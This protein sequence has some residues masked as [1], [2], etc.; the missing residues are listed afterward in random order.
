MN[1]PHETGK[2]CNQQRSDSLRKIFQGNALRCVSRRGWTAIELLVVVVCLSLLLA[3]LLPWMI[4]SRGLARSQ[5]CQERLRDNAQAT[6]LYAENHRDALPP[7][8]DELGPWP[9]HLLP[10]L[11]LPESFQQSIADG[12]ELE[13]RVL[14][15]FL[16]PEDPGSSNS[17]TPLSYVMN[18]GYGEFRVENARQ[19]NV[20]VHEVGIHRADSDWNDDGEVTAEENQRSLCTGVI[21]RLAADPA[22]RTPM[23]TGFIRAGDGLKYTVLCAESLSAQSWK[24]R[25]TIG[26]GFVIDRGHLQFADVPAET[27]TVPPLTGA[28]LGPFAINASLATNDNTCPAP[29]SLHGDFAHVMFCDGSGKQLS[30]NIDPLAWARLMSSHGAL[31][32]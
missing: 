26:L 17:L 23:T 29:S 3:L 13:N 12:K 25:N 10:W 19:P 2:I 16:C 11:P 30:E 7:L 6:L 14:P 20:S 28:D 9:V 32:E 21:W 27:S 24:G 4:G 15:V 31:S 1:S 8:E 22:L 5:Q 18:A